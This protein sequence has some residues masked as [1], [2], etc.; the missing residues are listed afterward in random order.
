MFQ[1]LSCRTESICFVVFGCKK[2]QCLIC[3][4]YMGNFTHYLFLSLRGDSDLEG[5]VGN[6]FLGGCALV[7][8]AVTLSCFMYWALTL[9]ECLEFSCN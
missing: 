9:V 5:L 6:V 8:L 7:V 4:F 3:L 2:S 1:G